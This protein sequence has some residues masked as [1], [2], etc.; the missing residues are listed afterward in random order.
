MRSGCVDNTVVFKAEGRPDRGL[1]SNC[2][3]ECFVLNFQL[4]R[5]PRNSTEPVQMTS[6]M[7]FIQGNG[8]IERKM[9]LKILR[10]SK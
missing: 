3:Q 9:F 8:C 5:V 10:C 6:S 1:E 2:G 4:L 7:K